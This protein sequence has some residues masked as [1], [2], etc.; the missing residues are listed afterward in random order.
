MMPMY[1]VDITSKEGNKF[2]VKAKDYQFLV[3]LK[4]NIGVRHTL[5]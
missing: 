4:G 5:C 2:T 3:D 1:H